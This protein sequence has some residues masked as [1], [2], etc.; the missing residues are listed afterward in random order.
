MSTLKG[1]TTRKKPRIVV[2]NNIETPEDL[3]QAQRDIHLCIDIMYIQM[4]MFLVTVSKH[5]KYISI[6]PIKERSRQLVFVTL[7]KVFKVYNQA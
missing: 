7:D 4:Q 3:K 2:N 5:I 1:K 6:D